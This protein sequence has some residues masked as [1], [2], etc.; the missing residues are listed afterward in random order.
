MTVSCQLL[1]NQAVQLTGTLQYFNNA[2]AM[3]SKKHVGRNLFEDLYRDASGVLRV[4]KRWAPYALLVLYGRRLEDRNPPKLA[5]PL[6]N[7]YRF[8]RWINDDPRRATSLYPHG[9][10]FA[11]VSK[12]VIAF[13]RNIH[14][15]LGYRSGCSQPGKFLKQFAAPP[16]DAIRVCNLK[17]SG[18][19]GIPPEHAATPASGTCSAATS[20]SPRGR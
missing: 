8:D 5:R 9:R 19:A 2:I 3:R 20:S 14:V 6:C 4:G 15:A 10:T 1:R 18:L 17:C 7:G 16:P 11:R 13:I 12:E